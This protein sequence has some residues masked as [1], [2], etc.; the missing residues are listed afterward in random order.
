MSKGQ[1]EANEVTCRSSLAFLT[2]PIILG[3]LKP[4]KIEIAEIF[5]DEEKIWSSEDNPSINFDMGPLRVVFKSSI[6]IDT[7]TNF[8]KAPAFSISYNFSYCLKNI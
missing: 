8:F 3:K 6:D 4:K 1:K 7:F 2:N 5:K